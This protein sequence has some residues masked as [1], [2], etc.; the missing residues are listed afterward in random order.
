[1]KPKT[2][3]FRVSNTEYYIIKNKANYAGIT[4]SEFLRAIALDYNLSYKLTEE[5]IEIYKELNKYAD[6]FRRIG[7]LFKLGDSTKVKE[8]SIETAQ[9]IRDHLNRLKI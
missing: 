7:N 6:N 9:L 2:L 5:E 8:I 4:T 1:M 3:R